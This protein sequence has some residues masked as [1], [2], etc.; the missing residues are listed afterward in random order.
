MIITSSR[1]PSKRSRTLC[2]YLAYFFNTEYINR[3]KAGIEDLIDVASDNIVL[4]IGDRH[5]NPGSLVLY[6]KT[7]A[8]RLSIYFKLLDLPRTKYSTSKM[9]DPVIVGKTEL[10]QKLSVFTA[11]HKKEEADNN[12]NIIHSYKILKVTE[13]KLLFFD[14]K[15]IIFNFEI[16]SYRVM[17]GELSE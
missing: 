8:S 2:K 9:M 16:I 13:K 1:K 6:Y 7:D 10:A 14:N 11:L 5:G 12:K 15:S 17:D 4:S 3:G